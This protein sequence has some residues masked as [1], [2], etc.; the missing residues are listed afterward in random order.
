MITSM[1]IEMI[2]VLDHVWGRG[3]IGMIHVFWYR[4]PIGLAAIFSSVDHFEEVYCI[5][6]VANSQC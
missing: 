6:R 5:R 1:G 4:D 3:S 2:F